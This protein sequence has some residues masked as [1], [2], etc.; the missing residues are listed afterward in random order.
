MAALL[1]YSNKCNHCQDVIEYIQ[2]NKP[3]QGLV[4]FHELSQGIPPKYQNK[5]ER[6]PT[7]LTTNG[8][9]FVGKEIKQWL[10][11]LLP[12]NIECCD[13][14]TNCSMSNIEDDPNDNGG[15]FSLDNYGQ[16]LQPMMTKELEAKINK[17]VSDAFDETNR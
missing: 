16:S 6:V 4:Q 2:E 8:K 15:L 11:S 17:K 10:F 13:L 9:M 12:N 7:L 5:I 3:L 14:T 1:I